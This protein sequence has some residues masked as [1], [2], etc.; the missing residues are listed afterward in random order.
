MK[1]LSIIFRSDK[2]QNNYAGFLACDKDCVTLS[3][4]TQ[5]G[6]LRSD[7]MWK[8]FESKKD[9]VKAI[10]KYLSNPNASI[11]RLI[12]D[13]SPTLPSKIIAWWWIERLTEEA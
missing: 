7:S 2:R 10:K 8:E 1:T 6:D 5:S 11:H 3:N 12:I 13:N 4:F 9:F